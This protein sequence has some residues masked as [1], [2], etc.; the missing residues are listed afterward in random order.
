[1][2]VEGVHVRPDSEGR[3]GELQRE[4][5]VPRQ[6]QFTNTIRDFQT[7][8][9]HTDDRIEV[10]QRSVAELDAWVAKASEISW[11]LAR[12]ELFVHSSAALRDT[13]TPTRKPIH[14]LF[15]LVTCESRLLGRK[16]NR[17]FHPGSQCGRCQ[18][19]NRL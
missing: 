3:F 12:F 16:A 9:S 10:L 5:R 6:S 7:Q 17:P 19:K 4:R 8:L 2:D 13:T 15:A 18:T 14:A 11:V 1:M